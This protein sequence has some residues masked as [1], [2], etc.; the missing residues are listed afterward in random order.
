[1]QLV[2]GRR[3]AELGGTRFRQPAARALEDV[4]A[5]LDAAH[6][7]GTVHGAIRAQ[8][9]F[10]D[11]DGRGLLS[12]FGLGVADATPADD[13]RAFGAL[14]SEYLEAG[15]SDPLPPSAREIVRA[16][17]PAHRPRR[18]WVIVGAAPAVFAAAA[19]LALDLAWSGDTPKGVPAVLPRAI[20]LGS[21]LTG[22]AVD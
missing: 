15:V 2:H 20:A 8:N 12:D 14:V 16:A 6:L 3:L 5:A 17:L 18:R 10:V 13:L 9:V 21:E 4:A 7:A 1:M 11:H 22:T 19:A